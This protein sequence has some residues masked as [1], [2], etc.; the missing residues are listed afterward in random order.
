MYWI[1][2]KCYAT[3][4]L[5]ITIHGNKFQDTYDKRQNINS[6]QRS[7]AVYLLFVTTSLRTNNIKSTNFRIMNLFIIE[8]DYS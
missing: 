8:C 3:Y 1:K 7:K 5:L 6:I 4:H 2:N